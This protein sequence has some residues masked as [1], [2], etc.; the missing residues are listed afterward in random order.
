VYRIE[1]YIGAAKMAV[2]APT[3]EQ[4]AQLHERLSY[5]R[6]EAKLMTA[7]DREE[8]KKTRGQ[9]VAEK[10]IHLG[11]GVVYLGGSSFSPIAV[12]SEFDVSAIRKWLASH[13]DEEVKREREECKMR[14]V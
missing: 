4:A 5:A 13:I 8:F 6:I 7:E 11:T 1:F 2:E 3:M 10:A 14:D 12:E 9:E